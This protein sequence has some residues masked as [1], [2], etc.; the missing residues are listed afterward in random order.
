MSVMEGCVDMFS[1]FRFRESDIVVSRVRDVAREGVREGM[2]NWLDRLVW[3][4]WLKR[5][6]W[7]V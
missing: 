3:I 2:L 6:G 5:L 1:R 4:V 7:F